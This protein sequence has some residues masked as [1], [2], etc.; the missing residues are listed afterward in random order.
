MKAMVNK[1]LT[2]FLIT[3]AGAAAETGAG[4]AD[5]HPDRVSIHNDAPL[6]EN[7]D[8][9]GV[10]AAADR[11]T[12]GKWLETSE[13]GTER[14]RLQNGEEWYVER[15]DF[16][17]VYR[18]IGTEPAEV[19]SAYYKD[20]P[21]AG[22]KPGK[23]PDAARVV[24]YLEPGTLVAGDPLAQAFNNTLPVEDETGF[25]GF[26]DQNRLELVGEPGWGEARPE[27]LDLFP[28]VDEP[29]GG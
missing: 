18:V 29:G 26:V 20:A 28:L 17:P 4:Q 22:K 13:V 6:Y 25:L 15:Y 24:G 21:E 11:W 7:A 1:M 3:A 19:L 12:F 9:T 10:K 23:K 2:V 5:G 8:R 16:Y 27:S 14:V